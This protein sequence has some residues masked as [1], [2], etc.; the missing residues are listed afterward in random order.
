M[1]R[2][3]LCL[4]TRA[5]CCVEAGSVA[6]VAVCGHELGEDAADYGAE[7]GER[8]ANDSDIAFCGGPVGGGDVAVFGGISMF[9][10]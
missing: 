3:E 2:V 5:V 6:A 7:E 1:L 8:G 4:K 10:V 9:L